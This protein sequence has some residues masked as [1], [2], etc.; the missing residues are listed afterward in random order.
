MSKRTIFV[1]DVHG[2]L[3]ELDELLRIIRCQ[4]GDRLIFLGDLIDRGPDPVGCVRRVRELQCESVLGNHEEKALRWLRY[5]AA[6]AVS[7]TPNPMKAPWPD[8]Q[9][10][11]ESL[12][13]DDVDWLSSLPILIE[14]NPKLVAVHAGLEPAFPL[15]RQRMNKV[16]RVRYV[17]SKGKMV[18]LG[19]DSVIQPAGTT[20]WSKSWK[21]PQSVIYGHAV[22]SLNLPVMDTPGGRWPFGLEPSLEM[23]KEIYQEPVCVGIDTGCVFG[24][25]LSAVYV[26]DSSPIPTTL[27]RVKAKRQYRS[28]PPGLEVPHFV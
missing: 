9:K 17:D 22:H 6:R 27:A 24:G 8:R 23:A 18:S 2:C 14:V 1:G 13:R 20:Y 16:I 5:E 3:E 10:E 7:G 12:S 19:E 4:S 28:L 21:G 25:Y 15:D 26:E 11:W